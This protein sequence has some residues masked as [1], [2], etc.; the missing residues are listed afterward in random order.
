MK[1]KEYL[2]ASGMNGMDFARLLR[3]TP[4]TVYRLLNKKGK[5]SIKLASKIY[6][7]TGGKVSIE[8]LFN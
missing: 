1:L 3:V 8:E 5:P 7:K 2:H 4:Q 6:Q